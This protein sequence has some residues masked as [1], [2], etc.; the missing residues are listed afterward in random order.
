MA[1]VGLGYSLWRYQLAA[2][3]DLGLDL[4]R[5]VEGQYRHPNRRTRMAASFLAIEFEDQVREAIDDGWWLV[6]TGRDVHH[7]KDAQPGHHAVQITQLALEATKNRQRRLPRRRV[8]LVE[9][10]LR[11]HFATRPRDGAVG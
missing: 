6:E 11:A 3:S 5:D 8:S 4:D 1:D 10:H 7:P 9:R 2:N